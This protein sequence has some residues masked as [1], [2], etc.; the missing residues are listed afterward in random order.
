MRVVEI[1]RSIQGEGINIGREATFLRLAGCNLT[2]AFCDT[3]YSWGT[4]G[5][6]MDIREVQKEIDVVRSPDLLVV[7]GGEPLLQA[8]E[9]MELGRCGYAQLALETNGTLRPP[10]GWTYD[11]IAISPKLSSAG[12]SVYYNMAFIQEWLSWRRWFRLKPTM[13]FKFVIC[14]EDDIDEAVSIINSAP[15]P[16]DVPIIFQPDGRQENYGL[17]LRELKGWMDAAGYL[18]LRRVRVLP[19]LHRIMWGP[20]AR[21]I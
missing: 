20:D 17:A 16:P 10:M 6:D 12:P 9:L 15:I 19:Q 5:K 2:C 4:A 13:E 14:S 18:T 11:H 3:K 21:G 7:T 8:K 1:F